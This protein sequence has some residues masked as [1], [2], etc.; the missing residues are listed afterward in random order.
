KLAHCEAHASYMLTNGDL[1]FIKG[2][3]INLTC[4]PNYYSDDLYI[5]K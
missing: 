1:Q 2:L 4:E 3:D 5:D